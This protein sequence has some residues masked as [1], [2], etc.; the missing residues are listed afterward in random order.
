MA[1]R[2]ESEAKKQEKEVKKDEKKREKVALTE[3]KFK[4]KTNEKEKKKESSS[5]KK[6]VTN[7]STWRELTDWRRTDGNEFGVC[8]CYLQCRR[9]KVRLAVEYRVQYKQ[10]STTKNATFDA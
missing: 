8:E 1:Q 7:L 6:V 2:E 9:Q 5:E 4:N 10:T 3:E